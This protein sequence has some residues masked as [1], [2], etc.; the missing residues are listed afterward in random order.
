LY[1]TVFGAEALCGLSG[2]VDAAAMRGYLEGFG[3]GRGLDIVHL[4]SLIRCWADVTDGRFEG[5]VRNALAS[6]L[7]TFRSDDGGYGGDIGSPTGTAYACFLALGACQDLCKDMSDVEGL[8][9]CVKSL[10]RDNGSYA[11][12]HAVENGATATTAAAMMVL[13]CLGRDI[14]AKTTDWMLRRCLAIGGFLAMELSP[15]P[16]MLSTATAI[17][18]LRTVGVDIEKI[19]GPCIDFCDSLWDVGGGF[20]G[21]WLDETVDCEY[22]YYG[23]LV[24]G[25]L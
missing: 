16:D 19:K 5:H 10:K 21:S 9:R 24:L 13:H 3:D 7:E 12:D 8:V 4:A 11:N 14:D 6:R 25:H 18:A 23:L 20:C 1:Y 17:H 2:H 15:I 22:T